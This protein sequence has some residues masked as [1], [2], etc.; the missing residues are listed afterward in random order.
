MDY[1]IPKAYYSVFNIVL[2]CFREI[3]RKMFYL[4]KRYIL[5]VLARIR[6]LN[7]KVN[8]DFS[9]LKWHWSFLGCGD[10]SMYEDFGNRSK[11]RQFCRRTTTQGGATTIRG[12]QNIFSKPL[13]IFPFIIVIYFYF[14]YLINLINYWLLL[15]S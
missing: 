5:E 9:I 7:R 3:T 6:R 2:V 10:Q 8:R 4:Y 11:S 15:V 13:F 12:G 14:I 1:A